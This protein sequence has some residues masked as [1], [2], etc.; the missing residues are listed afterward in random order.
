MIS[1]LK[2]HGAYSDTGLTWL[3]EMP[4]HWSLQRLKNYVSNTTKQIVWNS[5]QPYL[6]LEN[7]ES[8]TGK[9]RQ[10]EVEEVG[11]VVKQYKAGD[12]LF[13]K[14]RP[15][16]AKV[17]QAKNTGT[18]VGEFLVLR[19]DINRIDGTYLE[20]LLR[21]KEVINEINSSTF[22]ARMPRAEWAFIGGMRIAVPPLDEQ[23]LIA[24]L[25]TY[26]DIKL[27]T[28]IGNKQRLLRLLNEQRQSIIRSALSG[29]RSPNTKRKYSG[30]DW[31]GTIPDHWEIRSLAS[32]LTPRSERGAAELPLL[33]VLREKGVVLR[34]T[35]NKNEN[36]NFIPDDLSNY[37]VARR[38]DLVINKMKAWQG[39]LGVAPQDGIVSPA[40]YVFQLN[41]ENRDF[42]EMLLRSS[43]YVGMFA[44]VSEGVRIGQWDLSIDGMKRIPVIVP[45]PDEQEKIV[46]YVQEATTTNRT[47]SEKITREIM[48]LKEYRGRLIED[49]VLGRLSALHFADAIP[50]EILANT[51]LLDESQDLGYDDDIEETD[52][53]AEIETED[54]AI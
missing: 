31:L 1:D 51:N 34:S 16:L 36:H 27:S 42:S 26:V 41:V 8:W 24:R 22:G 28:Y 25:A 10:I 39:S 32:L 9:I 30:T 54:T 47:V 46:A 20:Y 18:C 17:V 38:G 2:K 14:L 13:S 3:P 40:Y 7:V 37:K 33:S 4:S 6:A 49:L 48:L 35:L 15:Y 11:T 5:D 19:P 44:R 21:S 50:D 43:A 53:I 29:S 23:L 52:S 12:V 45:P